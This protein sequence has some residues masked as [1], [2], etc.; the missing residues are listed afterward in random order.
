VTDPVTV[1]QDGVNI[2]PELMEKERLYHCFFGDKLM[3]F[4]KDSQDF[5]NCYEVEEKELVEQ[6]RAASD[7]DIEK[8]FA[9]YV[10]SQDDTAEP[11]PE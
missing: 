3:L 9:K 2:R 4:F 10:Q 6:A 7:A 11:N 8:I 1:N 5:L